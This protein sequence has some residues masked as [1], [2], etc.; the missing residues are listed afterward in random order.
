VTVPTNLPGM[1][2]TRDY[3]GQA[4]TVTGSFQRERKDGSTATVL[5]WTSHC[6][7]CGAPVT[8]TPPAASAKFQPNRRCLKHKRPG[9]RVKGGGNA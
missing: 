1:G 2:T 8:F 4:Y 5:E 9:H 7:E 6:A 3:R